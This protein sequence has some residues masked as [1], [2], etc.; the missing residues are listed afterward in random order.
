LHG[1]APAAVVLN[2]S[3]MRAVVQRVSRA[4]VTVGYERVGKIAAGLCVLVGVGRDDAEADADQLAEKVVGLRI[5]EDAEGRMNL[6]VLKVGGALLAV[7]QFTLF[8]DARKGKRPSFTSAMEPERAAALFERF[9]AR[10]RE[11]GVEVRTGR[12]RA[13]MRVE[14]INDGPVTILIDTRKVF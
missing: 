12:F 6:G 10:C 13:H 9:C 3:A 14:L 2:G 4:E 7:S 1:G 11:L 8:G 5:F